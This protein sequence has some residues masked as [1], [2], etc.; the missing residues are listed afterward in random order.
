MIISNMPPCKVGDWIDMTYHGWIYRPKQVA[1]V[2]SHR[3]YTTPAGGPVWNVQ[4]K[5]DEWVYQWSDGWKIV[6]APTEPEVILTHIDETH[7][8]SGWTSAALAADDVAEFRRACG[9]SAWT[10]IVTNYNYEFIPNIGTV[11]R[12]VE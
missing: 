2:F 5:G 9:R 7:D 1:K 11:N 6:D 8:V 3:R 12:S 10:S 4:F